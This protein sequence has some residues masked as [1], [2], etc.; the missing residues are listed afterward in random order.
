MEPNK[1]MEAWAWIQ[2]H[3][4]EILGILGGIHAIA[5]PIVQWTESKKDDAFLEMLTNFIAKIVRIIG[6]QPKGN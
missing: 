1:I 6:L 3:P 4:V 2:S 5:K